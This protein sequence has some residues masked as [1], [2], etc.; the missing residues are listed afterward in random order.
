MHVC[1]HVFVSTYSFQLLPHSGKI[2]LFFQKITASIAECTVTA[3]L[4]II[5]LITKS[6]KGNESLLFYDKLLPFCCES[7]PL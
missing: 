3:E 7:S 4:G 2:M 5:N 6:W 1:V